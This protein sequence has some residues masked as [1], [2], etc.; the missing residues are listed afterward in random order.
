[1]DSFVYMSAYS[2][3]LESFAVALSDCDDE[4]LESFRKEFKKLNKDRQKE[5]DDLYAQLIASYKAGQYIDA[6][7]RADDIE[8]LIKDWKAEL[9]EL[10]PESKWGTVAYITAA[11]LCAV[12]YAAIALNAPA[13]VSSAAAL[14]N[15]LGMV[16]TAADIMT[17]QSVTS[18]VKLGRAGVF[19]MV[20]NALMAAILPKARTAHILKRDPLASQYSNDPN[21]K[22]ATYITMQRSLDDSLKTLDSVREEIKRACREN[23]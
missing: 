2:S 21:G 15:K 16:K 3:A 17:P 8:K 1:M 19:N 10:P 12:A 18:L 14:F 20:V 5:V 23:K 9:K 7:A 22:N 4:A 11:M 6:L 13:T